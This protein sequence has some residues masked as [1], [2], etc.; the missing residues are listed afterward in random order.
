MPSFPGDRQPY[1]VSGAKRGLAS[2]RCKGCPRVLCG[3]S[4]LAVSV[5][6]LRS[7]KSEGHVHGRT[8][9]CSRLVLSN[10][11]FVA[12]SAACGV[13]S[14]ELLRP[15]LFSQDVPFQ[16]EHDAAENFCWWKNYTASLSFHLPFLK[17]E[18]LCP[19]D[20]MFV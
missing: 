18:K 3:L 6:N 17:F 4:I 19:G 14:P 20:G 1:C 5:A 12:A 16:F 7:K 13:P 9:R 11:W 2:S 15:S 10:V 8:S